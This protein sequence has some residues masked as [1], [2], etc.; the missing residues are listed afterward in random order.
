[1]P[2][3]AR[4][5]GSSR[6]SHGETAY[7]SSMRSPIALP[8]YPKDFPSIVKLYERTSSTGGGDAVVARAID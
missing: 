8:G 6:T 7:R 5:K 4:S 2:S 3:D 1:M